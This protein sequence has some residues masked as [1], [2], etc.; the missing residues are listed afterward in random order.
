MP[1]GNFS[2]GGTGRTESLPAQRDLD[3]LDL[4]SQ[5]DQ[6]EDRHRESMADKKQ[7]SDTLQ[8]IFEEEESRA[9]HSSVA[10]S[11]AE[12]SKGHLDDAKEML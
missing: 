7:A 9:N 2:L 6:T 4:M 10:P 11:V 3:A 12:E 1:K 5:I 8:T